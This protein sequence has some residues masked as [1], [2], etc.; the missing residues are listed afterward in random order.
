MK[1]QVRVFQTTLVATKPGEPE[2]ALVSC[3]SLDGVFQLSMQVRPD[4]APL[5]GDMFSITVEAVSSLGERI[6]Q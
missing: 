6:G 1:A 3:R 4:S 5:V 2:A